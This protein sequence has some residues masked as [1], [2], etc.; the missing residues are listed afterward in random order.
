MTVLLFMCS[1]CAGCGV[2]PSAVSASRF[3][4]G[5]L[6]SPHMGSPSHA[7]PFHCTRCH[8]KM[9]QASC[10]PSRDGSSALP[11]GRPVPILASVDYCI[12]TLSRLPPRTGSSAAVRQLVQAAAWANEIGTNSASTALRR[13]TFDLTEGPSPHRPAEP[14]EW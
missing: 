3:P 8:R 14:V 6:F 12:A 9:A 7:L 4:P 10:W 5:L 11:A 2:R 1:L 13:R